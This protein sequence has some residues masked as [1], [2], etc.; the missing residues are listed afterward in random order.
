MKT[1]EHELFAVDWGVK[2]ITA[3]GLRDDLSA[4]G[5][6]AHY[7]NERA[8]V[9]RFPVTLGELLEEPFE[10]TAPFRFDGQLEAAQP[11]WWRFEKE[12]RPNGDRLTLG[13]AP[14]NVLPLYGE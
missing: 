8:E 4:V 13:V 12:R 11:L 1:G 14:V 7:F 6:R 2:L 9:N 10:F 5:I 3:A